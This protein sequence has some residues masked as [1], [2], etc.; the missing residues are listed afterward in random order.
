MTVRL[1]VAAALVCALL[2]G[3]GRDKPTSQAFEPTRPKRETPVDTTRPGEIAEGTEVAF[4]L[5]LPRRSRVTARFDD[6]V[7]AEGRLPFDGVQSYLRARLEPASEQEGASRIVLEAARLKAD[8]AR[9]VQV[10]LSRTATGVEI[11]VRERTPRPLTEPELGEAERWRRAG[12]TPEG[13]A[14]G[15]SEE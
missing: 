12:L 4:G 10:E 13:E 15:A 5:V 1:G 6:A 8:P 11:V 14:F 9:T 2:G 7:I 3:C